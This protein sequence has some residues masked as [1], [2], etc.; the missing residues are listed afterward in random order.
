[1][2]GLSDNWATAMPRRAAFWLIVKQEA[3]LVDVLVVEIGDGEEALP[4]FSFEEEARLFLLLE[5]LEASWR[6]RE[7]T[8]GEV[9]F[10]LFGPCARVWRV[11]LAPLPRVVGREVNAHL[12]VERERF[13]PFPSGG[14]RGTEETHRSRLSFGDSEE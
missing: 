11:V 14:R 12:S 13:L 3:G 9:I 10:V 5:N 7:T 4:L 1:M 2:N 8:V 6:V